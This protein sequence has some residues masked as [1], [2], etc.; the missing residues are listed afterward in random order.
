MSLVVSILIFVAF[1]GVSW[2]VRR[3]LQ[4]KIDEYAQLRLNDGLSGA[5]VAR[6]M[7]N[8]NNIQDV[9]VVSVEGTLTDHYNPADKTVNLSDDIYNGRSVA[10]AA[11]AAHECGHAVQHSVAYAPV[12]LWS[13]IVPVVAAISSYGQW[14][15]FIGVAVV[16]MNTSVVPLSIVAC[17]FA[18]VFLFNLIMLPVELDAS[19]RALSWLRSRGVVA[20]YEYGYAGEL[21][22]WAAMTYVTGRHEPAE[23]SAFI[24]PNLFENGRPR[25]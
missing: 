19:R 25:P 3:H 8:D 6:R 18:L 15:F 14:I 4:K 22:W 5:Q 17:F 24:A 1:G 20:E 2:R 7:L 11:I 12:K 10:S 21:L 9:R 16:L 13:V 23:S